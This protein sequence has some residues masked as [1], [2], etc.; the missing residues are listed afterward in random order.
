MRPTIPFSAWRI[1]VDLDATR[2]IRRQT[3]HPA[4]NCTCADCMTWRN[5]ASSAFP[6]S[7]DNG[8]LRLGIEKDK[9]TDLYVF[10][11]TAQMADFR[12]IYHIV[13][14]VLSGPA[15]WIKDIAQS[16]LHNYHVMQSEPTWIG[17][18]VSTARDSYEYAPKS[19]KTTQG[20]VLCIDF[21]IATV[22]T[23]TRK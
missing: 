7:L 11:R 5:V 10:G 8:L 23:V 22:A 3:G 17:L 19:T 2:T 15:P 6:P 18:R 1:A 13:G 9:P 20:D 21:R 4:E 12:V 14:R 16:T